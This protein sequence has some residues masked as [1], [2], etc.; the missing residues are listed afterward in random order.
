ML[1]QTNLPRACRTPASLFVTLCMK[2]CSSFRDSKI[3]FMVLLSISSYTLIRSLLCLGVIHNCQHL[4]EWSKCYFLRPFS[5]QKV[6]T[7]TFFQMDNLV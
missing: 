5:P 4:N 1:F 2:R 7:S 6:H 3:Y